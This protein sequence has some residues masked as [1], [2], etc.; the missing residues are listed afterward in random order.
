M[1]LFQKMC[2]MEKSFG[3]ISYR[4]PVGCSG[5]FH[6]SR[7]KLSTVRIVDTCIKMSMTNTRFHY[8]LVFTEI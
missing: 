8:I 2:H 6:I 3:E 1:H 5:R 4:K 7:K